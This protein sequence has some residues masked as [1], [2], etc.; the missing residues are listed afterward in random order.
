[1]G[2]VR[3]EVVLRRIITAETYMLHEYIQVQLLRVRE[4]AD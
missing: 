2:R 3:A 1:M 4:D